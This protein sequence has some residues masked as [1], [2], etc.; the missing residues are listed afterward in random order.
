MGKK[1]AASR[2]GMIVTTVA[3]EPEL[4]RALALASLEEHAAMSALL[5][6]AAREWLKRRARK[7]KKGT[8][9]GTTR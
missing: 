8:K 7:Q 4:H 6:D 5:R 3:L 1:R 9:G 2:E